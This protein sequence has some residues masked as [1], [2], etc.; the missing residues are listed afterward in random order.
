MKRVYLFLLLLLACIALSLQKIG[1]KDGEEQA[2]YNG[3][4][5][6]DI[7]D[8]Q[9][10]LYRKS[11][12]QTVRK[13]LSGHADVQDIFKMIYG[14]ETVYDGDREFGVLKLRTTM[15]GIFFIDTYSGHSWMEVEYGDGLRTTFALHGM[16]FSSK[17]YRVD[18]DL[19]R[20]VAAEMQCPVTYHQLVQILDYNKTPEHIAWSLGHNCTD[21]AIEVWNLISGEKIPIEDFGWLVRPKELTEWIKI[22]K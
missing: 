5:I 1:Y 2:S 13:V 6:P 18:W 3:S 12:Q 7:N 17:G 15:E 8:K 20:K 14:S 11:L 21:Y 9:D 10:S 19:N 22:R 16:V 4:E